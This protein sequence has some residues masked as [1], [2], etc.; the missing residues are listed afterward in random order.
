MVC[1]SPGIFCSLVVDAVSG[2]ISESRCPLSLDWL[3]SL[4]VPGTGD[5]PPAKKAQAI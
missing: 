4:L 2:E 1:D 5:I 3:Y